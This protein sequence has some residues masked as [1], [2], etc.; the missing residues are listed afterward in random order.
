MACSPSSA[1]T[2][3]STSS[4]ASTASPIAW[5][6]AASLQLRRGDPAALDAYEAHGRIVAGTLDDHLARIAASWIDHH[7]N[8]R[9]LAVVAS[10]NDHV[11]TINHAIQSARVAGRATS[12]PTMATRIAAGETAHVGD[13]VATRRNDRRLVTSHG[14]PVRNRDT[15]T[16]TAIHQDGSIAVS[17]QAGHGDVTLPADYVRDHVRLGYAATEHGWQSDTVDTAIALTSPAT[18]R[19]GLYVAATRGRDTNTLCVVTDSDDIAEARDVLEAVL[20]ADRADVPATTQRRTL[21]QAVHQPMTTPIRRCA[22]PDWFPTVLA[23]AQRA[24][25]AAEESSAVAAIRRAEATDAVASADETLADVAAATADDR[26]ALRAAETRAV[27]A[28]RNHAGAQHRLETAP[29]RQRRTAR[30]D[31]DVADHQLERAENYLANTRERTGPAV[32]RHNRAVTA[33][34]DAHEELRTCDAI[35]RLDA[36]TP[37]VGEHRMRVRA[38]DVWKD[39]ADGH[40]VPDRSLRTVAAI[41]A[42]RAGPT[43]TPRIAPRRPPPA[44][45]GA[46]P[47]C[48]AGLDR[49]T[50]QRTRTRHR[51]LSHRGFPAPGKPSAFG[52]SGRR[53][54]RPA[55]E[56]YRAWSWTAPTASGIGSSMTRRRAVG[57]RCRTLGKVPGPPA[58]LRAE[59]AGPIAT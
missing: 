34:R 30:H 57:E 7:D 12:T 16:V 6:A 29:R 53:G 58:S 25:A 4:N 59:H 44:G 39:W 13:V 49:N 56:W 14:E 45:A 35:D 10:T 46:A 22:V 5:E 2:D 26:D 11:A 21:A 9:T 36:M 55:A 8:G 47:N 48:R 54:R 19:R 28:R 41:L 18:T 17:H 37:S 27:D 38:L 33:Q 42:Q 31:L 32:E 20:A 40:P 23:D 43:P 50:I 3:A 24:L 15:W 52:A 1:P 51:A